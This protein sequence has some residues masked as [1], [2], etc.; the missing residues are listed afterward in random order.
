LDASKKT[1]FH[2]DAIL[3]FAVAK[4]FFSMSMPITFDA[5]ESRPAANMVPE[6]QNGSSNTPLGGKMYRHHNAAKS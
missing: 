1:S 5:P 3:L 2:V 6:P 4:Y